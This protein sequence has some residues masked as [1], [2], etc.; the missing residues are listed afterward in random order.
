MLQNVNGG[1]DVFDACLLHQLS[2]ISVW[3][4]QLVTI[5]ELSKFIRVG[6]G[7]FRTTSRPQSSRFS[8]I[9]EV[10]HHSCWRSEFFL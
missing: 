5:D 6:N 7:F 9:T 1:G 4:T 8:R 10:T 2:V 3:I